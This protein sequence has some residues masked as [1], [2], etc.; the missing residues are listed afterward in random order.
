MAQIR[1]IRFWSQSPMIAETR[2]NHCSK[3]FAG[4]ALDQPLNSNIDH[5]NMHH[6]FQHLETHRKFGSSPKIPSG[7]LT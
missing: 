5:E 3:P 1:L 2:I 6:Q 4:I 7:N